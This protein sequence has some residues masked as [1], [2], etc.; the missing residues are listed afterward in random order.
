MTSPLSFLLP[1]TTFLAPTRPRP[2]EASSDSSEGRSSSANAT[3]ELPEA[4]CR[5][6]SGPA[7]SVGARETGSGER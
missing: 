4:L 1:T 2:A 7:D 6:V 5:K 3:P